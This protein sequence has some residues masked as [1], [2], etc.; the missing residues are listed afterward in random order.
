[1]E[2]YITVKTSVLEIIV[3]IIFVLYLLFPMET[4]E[5]LLSFAN[6]S[7]GLVLVV[8]VALYLILYSHPVLAI[9][10]LFVAFEFF[11]RNHM[12]KSNIKHVSFDLTQEHKDKK[13]KKMNPPKEVSLEEQVIK[14]MAPI[15]SEIVSSSYGPVLDNT[16][17]AMVI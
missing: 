15:K 13:M 1:M 2:K 17:H 9:L 4:P 10:A 7:I 5:P 6:S 12:S 8:L 11:R 14:N 3:F 16:H